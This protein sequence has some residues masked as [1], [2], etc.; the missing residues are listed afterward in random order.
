MGKKH[1][2]QHTSYYYRCPICR[3]LNGEPFRKSDQEAVDSFQK[4]ERAAIDAIPNILDLVRKFVYNQ[5]KD[6]RKLL[7]SVISTQV[8]D[9]I[10]SSLEKKAPLFFTA[11]E[12]LGHHFT[13][14]QQADLI[15]MFFH[16]SRPI[17]EEL[18]QILKTRE[19]EEKARKEREDLQRRLEAQR[20]ATRAAFGE[21]ITSTETVTRIEELKPVGE[22]IDALLKQ[23]QE[24]ERKPPEKNL[25]AK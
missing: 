10:R 19:D 7:P 4:R 6:A 18:T 1:C 5:L 20:K 9:F 17:R 21:E 22:A 2:G 15:E 11:M 3:R 24:W 8:D 13:P 12:T 16:E 25:K 14:F 23:Y